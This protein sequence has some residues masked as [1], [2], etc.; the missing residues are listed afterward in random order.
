MAMS[1]A[2]DFVVAGG[3]SKNICL[4]DLR[5]KVLLKR[6]AVTQ[7]RSLDGVLYK[8]NSK[9]MKEGGVMQHEIDALDSDLEE[10]AWQTK[11]DLPGVKTAKNLIKRNT[12][13]AVRV[14]CVKFSPDGTTFAAA[15][16]EG[17]IIYSNKLG[18]EAVFN[19]VWIDENVTLD[20][21]IN[22][23]KEE[24]YLNAMGLALRLDEP[25][26]IKTV[27]RSIPISSVSL[28]CA[29]FPQ[30]L[31]SR[32]LQLIASQVEKGTDVEWTMTWLMNLLKF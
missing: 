1:P 17:L 19:P 21:V 12:K 26:V 27:Y 15:T 4:Y 6:F 25:E 22:A 20:N 10:D 29:N 5:H 32:L 18:R 24:Q 7:N 8:L 13:L 16:T 2:G 3:N 31:L 28:L 9:N 30:N 11:E 23:V 14:K